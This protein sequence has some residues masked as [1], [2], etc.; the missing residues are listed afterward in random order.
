MTLIP[1]LNLKCQNSSCGYVAALAIVLMV[2]NASIPQDSWSETL[3]GTVKHEEELLRLKSPSVKSGS[4]EPTKLRINRNQ[5]N[6]QP[7]SGAVD[8]NAFSDPLQG[9][10]EDGNL[11]SGT[12]KTD[13]FVI[14]GNE[15]FDIG[16]ERNSRE[17]VLA[18]ERWHKQLAQAVYSR[19]NRRAV[20]AGRATMRITVTRDH[21]ISAEILS[22][23]GGPVFNATL[24]DAV[25]SLNGNPGL[26]FPAKSE[27]QKV[28]FEG[29]YIAGSNINPGYSWI[30]ND[31][32]KVQED[33]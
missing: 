7:A 25:L 13:D 6:L 3:K 4:T 27:R 2:L 20:A 23:K 22:S 28:S 19:W 14:P 33:F 8:T 31:F 30:K 24:L 1:L 12:V 18:W 10:V 9:K 5:T 16:A 26:N 15:K 29:D 11:A 32:E 21:R 17:L